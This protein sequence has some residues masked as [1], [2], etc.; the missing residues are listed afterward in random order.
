[1]ERTSGVL[2]KQSQKNSA[3]IATRSGMKTKGLGLKE[4]RKKGTQMIIKLQR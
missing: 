3:F 1:M 2:T 4:P